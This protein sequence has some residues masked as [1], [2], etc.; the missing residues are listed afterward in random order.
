MRKLF[1]CIAIILCLVLIVPVAGGCS[2]PEEENTFLELLSLLPANALDTG[3]FAL[4]D[5]ESIRNV[6]ELPLY[7]SDNQPIS[8][9]EFV[10][11][12]ASKLTNEPLDNF[13][14][15]NFVSYFTG[16][17]QPFIT[18]IQDNNIGY[19]LTNIDAE[20]NNVNFSLSESYQL[21]SKSIP[22]PVLMVAGIGR[23]DPQA[24]EDALDNRDDWPLWA[25]ENYTRKNYRDITIHS[26]VDGT[27]K[28]LEDQYSPPHL[29]R[30]GRALPLA[31]TNRY[32][33]VSDSVQN[34]ESMIDASKDKI[35]SLADVPEYALVA[36]GLYELGSYTSAIIGD[37]ALANGYWDLYYE[38][39]QLKKFL[40]FGTGYGKDETGSYVAL[41]LVHENSNI[42]MENVSLLEQRINYQFTLWEGKSWSFSDDIYDTKIH[43]DGR[44]LLAKLYTDDVRL[45]SK[46]FTEQWDLVLHES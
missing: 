22:M 29:D 13:Q 42:A 30:L 31:V 4:T 37:E 32:L 46:W 11:I 35:K 23:F 27:N 15:L 14:A 41:V 39:P 18:P 26:W 10:S 21:G 12:L 9:D 24:T 28:H 45:W 16:W 33:F 36:E 1:S 5:Y 6:I 2:A 7:N 3:Y 40:T 20:I 8:R 25:R 19:D 38:G 34:V 44:V 17:D 43:T